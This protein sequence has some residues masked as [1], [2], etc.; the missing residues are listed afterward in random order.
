MLTAQ[1]TRLPL[2]LREGIEV[3]SEADQVELDSVPSVIEGILRREKLPLR[4]VPDILSAWDREPRRTAFG[5][6]QA[7]T[8][9]AHDASPELRFELERAAGAYLASVTMSATRAN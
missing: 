3:L 2:R 9:A 8:L 4:L 6:S 5:V 7:I 1:V